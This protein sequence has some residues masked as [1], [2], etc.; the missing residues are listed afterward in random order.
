MPVV[1]LQYPIWIGSFGWQICAPACSRC[2]YATVM[3]CCGCAV[4]PG[5]CVQAHTCCLVSCMQAT[6]LQCAWV[7][8]L[9]TRML[10]PHLWIP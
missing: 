8:L 3:A 1:L 4:A 10:H 5:Y 7:C 9:Q 2:H 6:F